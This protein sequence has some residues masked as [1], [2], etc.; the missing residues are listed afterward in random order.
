MPEGC[1]VRLAV[2]AIA[3]T[4]L[5]LVIA[6]CGGSGGGSGSTSTAAGVASSATGTTPAPTTLPSGT[7]SVLTY[8]V[9]GLPQGISSSNPIVN[10]P[11]ISPKLNAYDLVLVQEDFWYH[12]ELAGAALHPYQSPTHVGYLTPVGDGLNTFATHPFTPLTRVKW[13][14]WFGLFS[15]AW[16]GLSSKGFTFSRHALGP[17]VEVDVY[18]LHADAGGDPGDYHARED[19]FDQLADFIELHSTGRALIVA[20]DTNLSRSDP[21]D[22]VCL[23]TFINRLGLSEAGVALN[24]PDSIDRVLLRDDADVQLVPTRWR[25]ADEMVT[26]T[27]APLSDHEAVHV[28]LTW[29]RLR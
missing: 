21:L 22:L 15:N 7:L 1:A 9:A 5:A 29:R 8:N 10:M 11:L 4:L 19:E 23:T 17:G 13:N 24:A 16:D 27:G 26:S 18:D 20:G 12:T 14:T 28:D 6:G 3:Q 2:A 25:F